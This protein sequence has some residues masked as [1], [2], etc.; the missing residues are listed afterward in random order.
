M[1]SFMIESKVE[2]EALADLMEQIDTVLDGHPR[3]NVLVSLIS[4]TLIAMH[5][6]ISPEELQAGVKNVSKYICEMIEHSETGQEVIA[7]HS[8]AFETEKTKMN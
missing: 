5:P 3:P 8:A 6:E 4:T 2:T 7:L 1:S